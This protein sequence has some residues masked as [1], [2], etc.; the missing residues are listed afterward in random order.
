MKIKMGWKSVLGFNSHFHK[1][2]KIQTMNPNTPILGNPLSVLS[3]ENKCANDK[4]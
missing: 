3:I 2:G 4:Y 1:C